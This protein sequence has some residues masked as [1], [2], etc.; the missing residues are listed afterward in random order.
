MDVI[1]RS[2][3]WI[4]D[5]VMALPA[6]RTLK[7]YAPELRIF[8]AAK[9]YLIDVYKNIPEIHDVIPIPNKINRETIFSTAAKLK[10]Y[11]FQWG[12]LFT[13]SFNSALLFKLARIPRLAGYK[14][15]MRGLM[16]KLKLPFPK[17]DRHHI[18]FYRDLVTALVREI[19]G[20]DAVEQD[21]NNH[22]VVTDDERKETASVLESLGVPV[23][24]PFIG[25]S[26]SAAYGT[27]KQWLP[28]RFGELIERV[29]GKQGAREK[30]L[31]FGSAGERE[32]IEGIIQPLKEKS[33]AAVFN[34]A[35][36]LTLRQAIVAISMCN[37]FVSNDS[38]LMHV[39]SALD[40]PL[41]AIFGPTEHHKTGPLNK[42]VRIFH[43]PQECAPCR[44]RDCPLEE[45]INHRCMKA[46]TVDEVVEQ[47]R[48][49]LENPTREAD[50]E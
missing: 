3:N 31:L 29:T 1:I 33:G 9:S 16:L 17:N 5:C 21:E 28:E 45:P 39:A 19:N 24:G 6:I 18:F 22:L 15:D 14:K 7:R 37:V 4:G 46:V 32:K 23:Q 20:K 12:L 26:P 35:G 44:H 25:I 30:I 10:S 43:Y 38:G 50:H 41:A 11:K 34:L 2:P 42:Q 8:I 13:N 27:A 47:V 40:L 48:D 49:F 36:K